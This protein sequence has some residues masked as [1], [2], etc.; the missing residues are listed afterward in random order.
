[1]KAQTTYANLMTLQLHPAL[2]LQRW[3]LFIGCSAVAEVKAAV[4]PQLP[5]SSA[6]VGGFFLFC[7]GF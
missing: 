3:D 4:T 2:L 1:M 6:L 7:F 5:C